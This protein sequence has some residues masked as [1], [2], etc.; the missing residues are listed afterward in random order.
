MKFKKFFDRSVVGFTALTAAFALSACGNSSNTT[1]EDE[2]DFVEESSS[3]GKGSS[4]SISSASSS[5]EGED[6]SNTLDPMP[7]DSLNVS[8]TLAPPT[9][10]DVKRLAPSVFQLLW[11]APEDA[12][13]DG[14]ILQRMA[15]TA[16]EWEDLG[17]ISDP[18][19]TRKIVE[20]GKNIDYYYRVAAF[21]G[22]IRSAYCDEVLVN[23]NVA[24]ESNLDFPKVPEFTANMERDSVLEFML[25]GGY[26]SKDVEQSV[27]N[28]DTTGMVGE[29]FFQARFIYG[30][31]YK[32]DTLKFALDKGAVSK[33]FD[34]IEDECNAYGQVR[35]GW[36]DKNGAVDYSD[37]S[38]PVG[39]KTGTQP[40]NLNDKIKAVCSDV[41]VNDNGFPAPTGFG[42]DPSVT[43]AHV[44]TWNDATV[45]GHDITRY[46]IQKLDLTKNVW[47]D[48]DSTIAGVTRYVLK[49][50][51]EEY[52]YYRLAARD[53][54]KELSSYTADLIV[55]S[56]LESISIA[57]PAIS[58]TQ[59]LSKDQLVL[60]WDYKDNAN[61]P[62]KG[63]VVQ[64]LNVATK[65]WE[66]IDSVGATIYKYQ[67]PVAS[68]LRY[69]RVAAYD[70]KSTVYSDDFK[71]EA[72]A[73]STF[74]LPKPEILPEESF[75][76]DAIVLTWNYVPSE[77]RPATG[78][79]VERLNVATGAWSNV[80][81]VGPNTKLYKVA[82]SD[83]IR[84]FR[85]GAYDAADTVYSEARRVEATQKLELA[86]PTITSSEVLS[87]GKVKLVWT[88]SA[89]E[90][91]RPASGF[92]V[93]Q[94][95][96]ISWSYISG[97]NMD[98]SVTTWVVDGPAESGSYFRIVAYDAKDSVYSS[99][100]YVAYVAPD[101]T[102][103]TLSPISYE[104]GA[105]GKYILSWSYAGGSI[106]VEKFVIQMSGDGLTWPGTNGMKY[107]V[108]N[109]LRSYVVDA[110]EEDRYY[111]IVAVSGEDS[112]ASEATFIP[113]Y[114]VDLSLP[115]PT[116]LGAVRIAPSIW[117]LTW[118]YTREAERP[119][120]GFLLQSSLTGKGNWD[121]VETDDGDGK[122]KAGVHYFYANDVS[123]AKV[124][125]N[126]EQY[127]RV[128]AYDAD[129]TTAYTAPVQLTVSTAYREDLKF[130]TP[131]AEV[132][133]YYKPDQIVGYRDSTYTE[134]EEIEVEVDDGEGGTKIE[135]QTVSREKTVQVPKY[136]CVVTGAEVA[137]KNSFAN[138]NIV[139]SEYTDTTMYEVRWYTSHIGSEVL[140]TMPENRLATR[141]KNAKGYDANVEY[142]DLFVQVRMIWRDKNGIDDYSE[143]SSP[144]R[145]GDCDK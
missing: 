22:N 129:D 136:E 88:Y 104:S 93:Q 70:D 105:K 68:E 49:N 123:E 110:P 45:P 13:I 17:A 81:K 127:F 6:I 72:N 20:N 119:E 44:L 78:F 85:V 99:A 55:T 18:T 118:E 16:S 34:T 135:K 90:K 89:G 139:Y 39:T 82:V 66:T 74:A 11:K 98:A 56:S 73:T 54:S 103:G 75:S 5:S 51:A 10:F 122:L 28:F 94:M 14:Y 91:N 65:L 138:K 35:V 116:G 67:I 7:T 48:Y 137:V 107:E 63:F 80:G 145:V 100:V 26:P 71:V 43:T 25:T 31:S 9:E 58:G 117:L 42:L 53:A 96:G 24:Y 69:F 79:V 47:V 86:T 134:T 32:S 2:D 87:G 108:S 131:S 33:K 46:I 40:A 76:K 133:K 52:S 19:I 59:E 27:Y 64:K 12:S 114:T 3:S 120:V 95:N 1:D 83:S 101:E 50:V 4:S 115:A 60:L 111:R 29:V 143:W 97:A 61:R 57:K 132:I 23:R 21:A 92:K 30:S 130:T 102:F 36:K 144:E 112:S 128:A 41:V 125:N 62:A 140:D 77:D 84:Y 121:Y 124:D 37:W 141:Y 109:S 113:A 106:E 8:T 15:P 142:R 38:A 126:L